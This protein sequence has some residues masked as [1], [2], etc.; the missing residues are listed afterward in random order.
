MEY[1]ILFLIRNAD[2][3]ILHIEQNAFVHRFISHFDKTFRSIFDGIGDIIGH[4]LRD[5]VLVQPYFAIRIRIV[6]YQTHVRT[7]DP[8]FHRSCHIIEIPGKVEILVFQFNG[9]GLYLGQVQDIVD[10][11]QQQVGV[12]VDYLEIFVFLLLRNGVGQQARES[13]NRVER[14]ADFV[15]HVGKKRRFQF[16]GLFGQGLRILQFF[17]HPFPFGHVVY[18]D[19]DAIHRQVF[20]EN[21][22]GKYLYR[23]AV[24][25]G[26]LH[27][28]HLVGLQRTAHHAIFARL[29]A[30]VYASVAEFAFLVSLVREAGG[31]DGNILPLHFVI[32][33]DVGQ[34]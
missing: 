1:F 22:S 31:T 23:V 24:I 30:S 25:E 4:N 20:P 27:L 34:S 10:Q 12:D 5:A 18:A 29:A 13:D 33:G 14:S 28:F 3:A 11:F 19:H 8:L 32:R 2:S 17:N 9:S 6:R 21:R 7:G 16:I 15:A 26:E